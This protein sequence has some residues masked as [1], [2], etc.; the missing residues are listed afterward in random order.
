M[1][2]GNLLSALGFLKLRPVPV[3]RSGSQLWAKLWAP[4][5]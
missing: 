2:H 1:E 5:G 4:N 3:S